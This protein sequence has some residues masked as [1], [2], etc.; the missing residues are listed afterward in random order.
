[1]M[2]YKS[3]FTASCLVLSIALVGIYNIQVN[4]NNLIEVKLAEGFKTILN[5]LRHSNVNYIKSTTKEFT[6]KESSTISD[7]VTITSK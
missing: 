2:I 5:D 3:V 7:E 4:N 1:M 6:A